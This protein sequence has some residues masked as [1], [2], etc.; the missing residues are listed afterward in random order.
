MQNCKNYCQD[1]WNKIIKTET[2][3]DKTL[4]GLPFPYL[5]PNQ[6]MFQEMYYWDT[7]FMCLGILGTKHEE[8][9][10]SCTENLLYLQRR[11]GRI[12]NSSRYYHLSRSQPPVLAL[13]VDLC[14]NLK[15]KIK[16]NALGWLEQVYPVVVSE[17]EMVWNGT[18]FPDYRYIGEVGLSRY[19]D[20]DI[21]HHSAEAESGWDMT[22]RFGNHCLNYCPVDLNCLLYNYSENLGLFANLLN[23]KDDLEHWQRESARRKQAIFKYCKAENGF[24]YDYDFV[25]HRQSLFMTVAGFF[26]LWSGIL[27][28]QEAA[29]LIDKFLPDFEKDY[30]IVTTEFWEPE[31]GEEGKQWAWPNG[32]APLQW[33]VIKGL[34]NYGSENEAR[35]IAQK[36]TKLVSDIFEMEGCNFEKYNVVDGQRAVPDRY[37]DQSGFGW[38]NA[39]FVR[40]VDFLET[41]ALKDGPTR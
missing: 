25:N 22:P 23:R 4:I 36:W 35:R 37:P 41:G 28:A 21:W 20:I 13:M 27:E 26:V 11:F 19:F 32:W 29:Y 9:I 17:Y 1:Y 5:T 14:Y 38:T 8:L 15:L 18:K 33:I 12:P 7:Y 30:G 6:H 2:Q 10:I 3:E 40:L 31:L 16:A 39:I 34:L 24:Y